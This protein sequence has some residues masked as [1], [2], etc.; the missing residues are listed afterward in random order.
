M[1]I[2][3]GYKTNNKVAAFLCGDSKAKK[4]TSKGNAFTLT[5][6]KAEGSSGH[7]K[8]TWKKVEGN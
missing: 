5:F 4:L 7:F 1:T 8:A 6:N 2:Y 3:E